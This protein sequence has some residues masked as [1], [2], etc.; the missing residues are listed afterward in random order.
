MLQEL[1]ELKALEALGLG[2]GT[3]KQ[4]QLRGRHGD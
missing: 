1:R 4:V 3:S 2:V